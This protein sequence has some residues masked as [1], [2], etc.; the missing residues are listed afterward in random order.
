MGYKRIHR[1]HE[2]LDGYYLGCQLVATE[3]V[4]SPKF[5]VL[6]TVRPRDLSTIISTYCDIT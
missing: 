6:V 5:I 1:D 2:A 3:S 4:R